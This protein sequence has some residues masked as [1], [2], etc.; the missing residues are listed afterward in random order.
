MAA[1]ARAGL[2]LLVAAVASPQLQLPGLG[3]KPPSIERVLVRTGPDGVGAKPGGTVLVWVEMTPTEKMHVYAKGA[4]GFTPVALAMTPTVG[5]TVGMPRYPAAER[6]VS[7]GTDAPV[8]VYTRP[9]RIVQPITIGRTA[10]VGDRVNV[11]G[12]VT[13]ESCDDRL[14]YPAAT[15]PVGWTVTVR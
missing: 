1:F 8:P 6:F 9:F 11:V 3:T 10:K 15:V 14:C 5:L 4:V 13:Y 2:A 12:A 7:P